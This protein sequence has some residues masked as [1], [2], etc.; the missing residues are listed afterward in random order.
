MKVIALTGGIGSGKS[1]VLGEFKLLGAG[2]I[3]CDE[4][5]HR[6]MLKGGSAYNEIT[7]A[8]GTD[9]LNSNGEIN[10]KKLADI[11]FS[12]REKLEVLNEISHRL[13]YD[14]VK[15][16]ISAMD[17]DV[18]CI[19][20]PL[21]FSAECPIKLDL[22]VA[23]TAPVETRIDRVI[24]RDKCTREQVLARME[25]QLTD[26]KLQKLAD[27]VIENNGDLEGLRQRV[28]E[29]YTSLIQ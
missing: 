16:M 22:T 3:S 11:V 2:I 10:R 4:I 27:C 23:V 25:N 17:A 14:E 13:I 6:I 21:L 28:T 9:I 24:C 15:R 7:E 19:E 29:I 1:T 20:I 5:S 18:V 8:F 12:D 26:E